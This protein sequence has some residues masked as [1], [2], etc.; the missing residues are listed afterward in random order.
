[1]LLPGGAGAGV[2]Q[3]PNL[4]VTLDTS[5]Q[6]EILAAGRLGTTIEASDAIELRL[7]GRSRIAGEQR[8]AKIAK[9]REIALEA[10][11]TANLDL[12]L[13][14]SGRAR[15]GRCDEQE[16]V[17]KIRASLA[18]DPIG[19]PD[20]TRGLISE[21]LVVDDPASAPQQAD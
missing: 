15:L 18:P 14:A 8:P 17:V 16:I 20:D 12:P 7:R 11:E 19:G 3:E 4:T 5:L 10:G 21:P 1:M 6:S 13:T 9:R 2:A